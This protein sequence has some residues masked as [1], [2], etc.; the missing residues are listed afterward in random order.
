MEDISEQVSFQNT[1]DDLKILLRILS[2]Y[3][4]KALIISS[5]INLRDYPLYAWTQV[6]TIRIRTASDCRSIRRTAICAA[7]AQFTP[8]L[9]GG[10]SFFAAR[11]SRLPGVTVS[12]HWVT[13]IRGIFRGPVVRR[14]SLVFVYRGDGLWYRFRLCVLVEQERGVES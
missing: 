7:R 9:P 10:F 6:Y 13:T 14:G 2:I 12:E 1:E 4:P 11:E 8:H 5:L 3:L